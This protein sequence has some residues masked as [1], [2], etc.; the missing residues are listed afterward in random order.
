MEPGNYLGPCMKHQILPLRSEV[1]HEDLTVQILWNPS[2]ERLKRRPLC[3]DT[4][5]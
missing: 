4:E 2:H 3:F 5:A 1:K